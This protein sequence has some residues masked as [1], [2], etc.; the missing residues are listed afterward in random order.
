MKYF[1]NKYSATNYNLHH[2]ISYNWDYL[3]TKDTW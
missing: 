1:S 2:I 3:T